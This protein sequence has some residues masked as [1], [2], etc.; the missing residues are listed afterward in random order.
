MKRILAVAV[1]IIAVPTSISAAAPTP[2]VGV[3]ESQ[4][5]PEGN[6]LGGAT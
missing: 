6:H 1:V 5:V 3:L 2:N 4:V